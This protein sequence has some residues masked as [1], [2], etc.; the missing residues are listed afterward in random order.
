MPQSFQGSIRWGATGLTPAEVL[1]RKI[2][3]KNIYEGFPHDSFPFDPQGWQSTSPIFRRLFDELKPQLVVELG[4]WKGASAL[5]MCEIAAGLRLVP[6]TLIC[7]DTWLGGSWHWL[8][9]RDPGAFASLNCSH[10]YPTLYAQFLANVLK[11]GFH[12]NIVPFPNTTDAAAR[13]FK[14]AQLQ[15]VDLIYVDASHMYEAVL[16]D[17]RNWWP[18]IRSGGAMFGDDFTPGYPG[19]E[20]AVN[21]FCADQ[22]LHFDVEGEKWLIRKP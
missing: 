18:F 21:E 4:T 20:R 22:G 2:H 8:E 11:S 13:F 19:V 1:V 17:L 14:T 5:H 12:R 3:E 16:S 6:F 7:V 10:G 15:Q 9:R